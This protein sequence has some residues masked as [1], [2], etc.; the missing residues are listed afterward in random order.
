MWCITNLCHA[1]AS[2]GHIH[3]LVFN[4]V[5]LVICEDVSCAYMYALHVY[6]E[7]TTIVISITSALWMQSLRGN[8]ITARNKVKLNA[9]VEMYKNAQHIYRCRA[10]LVPSWLRIFTK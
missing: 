10:D 5:V 1:S 3:S 4:V 8:D 7:L 2:E 9:L 6:R